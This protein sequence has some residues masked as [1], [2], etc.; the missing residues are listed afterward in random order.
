M[1]ILSKNKLQSFTKLRLKKY[2]ETQ[3]LFIVEGI[4]ANTEFLTDGTFGCQA[5]I[6]TEENVPYQVPTFLATEQQIQQFS[7][8]KT[9]Q[10]MIGIYQI[11]TYPLPP[12]DD[13]ILVLD[14]VQDPGNLGTIIRTCDW[15]GVKHIVCSMDTVDC[16]NSKV[17]Q[18]SMGSLCRVQVHYIPLIPWLQTYPH[19]IYATVLNGDNL[20]TTSLTSPCVIIMGNEGQGISKEVLFYTTHRLTIPHR[21]NS[22]LDSLNVA[23]ATAII[24]SHIR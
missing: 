4:K 10:G 12:V 20:F 24:L 22:P 15:F 5:L 16:F 9:P 2:R 11:P 14:N 13:T 21:G 18:A 8:Q 17:I 3:Q 23:I 7:S 19:P 1:E 6:T